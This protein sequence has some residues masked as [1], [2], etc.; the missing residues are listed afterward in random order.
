MNERSPVD[1]GAALLSTQR[2]LCGEVTPDLRVVAVDVG[3]AIRIRFVY[4]RPIDEDLRE[5][6][7]A[8]EGE[9]DGDYLDEKPVEAVAETQMDDPIK[10]AASETPVYHRREPDDLDVRAASAHPGGHPSHLRDD[11]RWTPQHARRALGRLAVQAALLGEVTR[12]LR[13]VIIDP[14][15]GVRVRLIYD[16]PLDADIDATVAR[17][18]AATRAH[19]HLDTTVTTHAESVRHGRIPASD[20]EVYAYA[21]NEGDW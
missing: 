2:A 18:N 15:D 9:V 6:V 5:I 7:S 12:D 4:D 19:L 10:L 14:S 17:V 16:G 3:D 20:P 21:R 13:A 11:G 8:V 1:L